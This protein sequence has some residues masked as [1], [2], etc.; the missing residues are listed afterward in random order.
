MVGKPLNIL[1]LL[2]CYFSLILS[3]YELETNIIFKQGTFN[4]NGSKSIKINLR[5]EIDELNNYIHI[6]VKPISR[7]VQMALISETEQ[8]FSERKALSIQPYESI[9]LFLTK[10]QIME[11]NEKELYLCVKCQNDENCIYDIILDSKNECQLDIG[12][13]ASYYVTPNNKRMTFNFINGGFY[14]NA[15]DYYNFWVKGQSINRTNLMANGKSIESKSFGYGDVYITDLIEDSYILTIQSEEGD[16]VTVGSTCISNNESKRLKVNDLEIMGILNNQ[17]NQICFPFDSSIFTTNQYLAQINGNVFT[18]KATM[19]VSY[20]GQRKS[21]HSIDNGLIYHHLIVDEDITNK[22]LC[23]TNEGLDDDS[24]EVIFS[25]QFT[26]SVSD[27]K[28]QYI[29]PPQLP[30]VIYSHFLPKGSIGV[31]RG[32]TPKK[33]ASEINFNM[34]AIRGYPDM[35]FDGALDFPEAEYDN[36]RLVQIR[37]PHHANRMTVFNFYLNDP[38]YKD[39]KGYNS[40]SAT[41]PLIIVQ[42]LEGFTD[43]EKNSLFCEFETSIFSNLDHITLIEKETF[44]Q[45]LLQCETDLYNI[46]LKNEKNLNKV[47]L[48]LI[49]FSGDVYFELENKEI[50]PNSHK[51][52]LSNK[53]FYSITITENMEKINFKVYAHKNSFYTVSYKLVRLNDDSKIINEIESGVNFIQSILVGDNADYMKYVKMTNIKYEEGS[54]FLMNFYS[55][56]CQFLISRVIKR[57]EDG[58]T[59]DEY[60]PMYDSYSQLIINETDTYNWKSDYTFKVD[61]TKDDSSQYNK[62]LCMLYITGLELS[63]SQEGTERTISVSE[64]VPQYYIFTK[65]YPYIKYTYF[66]SDR[67]NELVIDFNLLDKGTF[68][69]QVIHHYEI[70]MEKEIYRN[71]QIIMDKKQLSEICIYYDEVCPI[72]VFLE[73]KSIGRDRRLETT[74]YQVNGAPI[75][76]EKNAIKNDILLS[77][78]RK[79]Y[80]FDIGKDESGDITIDYIRGS[81]YIYATI[82]D[83]NK[84]LETENPDWRGMYKFPT[85]KEKTLSY[86]T[87][88]KKIEIKKEDTRDCDDGCYAL[89]TVQSSIFE[90]NPDNEYK[91]VPYRIVI[92][93][94]ILPDGYEQ[95]EYLVPKVKMKVNQFVTGNLLKSSNK[96]LTYYQVTLPYES[97]HIVKY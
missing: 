3:E 71:Y 39:L 18:K 72:D 15:Y 9:H 5:S 77:P 50:L 93:P 56:N 80:Y 45:Y 96:I 20:K 13:Q 8:C 87:Y 92:T 66:I 51:Y 79:R 84:G 86:E 37:N 4:S 91:Y 22:K 81:G 55:Q 59:D 49:V 32:M 1:N 88:L 46:N 31:F 76:L 23:I 57:Y 40:I 94:R 19:F 73:L 17:L 60:L 11:V 30:G 52:Y 42:C 36:E 34:K 38:A 43:A 74:I 47:Y 58:T 48:D 7:H 83:K 24:K 64:G 78:A 54:P 12:E 62:K 26:S 89:I 35:L 97:D 44:S 14:T 27:N 28:I 33:D 69:I 61:I 90:E 70:I 63:N 29:F 82:V 67:N 41:Q 21:E 95:S 85:S 6:K 53:I 2:I 10:E 68:Y 75:Y 65:E 25:L 16:Y